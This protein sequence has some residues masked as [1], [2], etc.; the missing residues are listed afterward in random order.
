MSITTSHRALVAFVAELSGNDFVAEDI[1][2]SA[3]NITTGDFNTRVKL[4]PATSTPLYFNSWFN[5]NR[6]NLTNFGELLVPLEGESFIRELN[7]KINNIEDF[8]VVFE[9]KD[10]II[11]TKLSIDDYLDEEI[12][13]LSSGQEM[14]TVLMAN[15]LSY[16]YTGTLSLRLR[17]V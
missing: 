16:L 5:Y 7:D 3:P 1:F 17:K 11:N 2:L 9:A 12:P 8:S 10:S 14:V 15:P 13:P 6:V 4:F